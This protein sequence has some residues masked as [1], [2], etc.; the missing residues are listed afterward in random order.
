MNLSLQNL[1]RL[2]VSTSVVYVSGASE[3]VLKGKD[4][5]LLG[6]EIMVRWLPYAVEKGV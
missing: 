2:M 5:V 4:H 1:N 6:R 3:I